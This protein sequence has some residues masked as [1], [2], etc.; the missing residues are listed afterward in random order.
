MTNVKL[1]AIDV[2]H[3]QKVVTNE[4][5]LEH[6]KQQGKDVE[7]LMV[8]IFGRDKR[9]MLSNN[10][11]NTL[12]MAITAA[13]GVLQKAGLRGSDIDMIV[14][15]S[16]LPEHTSPPCSIFIHEAIE[17]KRETICYDLNGNCSGMTIAVE[18]ITNYMKGNPD[19]KNAL[20]V[21]SDYISMLVN[22]DN[23]LTHGNFGDAACALLLEKTGEDSGVVDAKYYINSEECRNIAFPACGFSNIFR[24]TDKNDI[25]FKWLPFDGSA[26]TVPAIENIQ[27]L[28]LKH[29]LTCSDV[30]LFCLSQFAYKNITLIQEGLNVDKEKFIYI[31]DEYGYTAT[32]SPWIA[33]F[34]AEKRGLVKR[35]DYIVFWTIG[36]G[37]E[38]IALLLKY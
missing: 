19:V 30:N 9:Y 7:H 1:K 24:A 23:E 2:Y 15:C 17:G 34:E 25:Y 4:V 29:G 36:A 5:Y 35:G 32:T 13:K 27:Q 38:S 21:G 6:F 28:L 20:V 8:D 10:D 26:C 37:S 3:G 31:G 11:E 18:Q 12:S 16:M 22:P 33:L 14:F